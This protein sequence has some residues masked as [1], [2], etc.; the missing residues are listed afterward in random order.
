LFNN[1]IQSKYGINHWIP[2]TEYEAGAQDRFTSRF[3]TDFI[4]GE[5]ML[6]PMVSEPPLLFYHHGDGGSDSGSDDYKKPGKR[7]FSEPAKNVFKTGGNLWRYYHKQPFSSF[8]GVSEKRGSYN[9]N[10]SL[11]DIREHFQGRNETGKMNNLSDDEKYN[12]LMANLRSTLKIL[13]EKIEPKIY[14]YG[15]LKK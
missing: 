14:E 4:K 15:F 12:E 8:E 6:E 13:A 11:Y 10:A 1:N 5:E 3:M 2:F 9:V 7:I